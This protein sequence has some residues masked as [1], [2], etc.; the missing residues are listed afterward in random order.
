M[1]NYQVIEFFEIVYIQDDFLE[2]LFV[3]ERFDVVCK[4]EIKEDFNGKIVGF[5]EVRK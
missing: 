1:L 4:E 3:D 2:R 5:F